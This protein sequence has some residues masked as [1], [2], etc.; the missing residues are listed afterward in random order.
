MRSISRSQSKRLEAGFTL[1]ELIIVGAM[2]VSLSI[3]AGDL[4]VSHIQTNARA[5]SL[6][7]QREDWQRTTSFIESEIAMSSRILTAGSAVSIPASCNLTS[8]EVK[9]AL[10]LARDL[11]VVLYGVRTLTS[12]DETV[13]RTQWLGEGQDGSGYG[14][15][16]RLSLI[17]I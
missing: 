11:P 9:L 6:Q 8:S 14:V 1:S 3:L 10:D 12:T 7:R 15:L 17:H 16:I 5:E 4:M 2:G 13:D